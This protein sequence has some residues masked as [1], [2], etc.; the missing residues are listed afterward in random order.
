M[1]SL[2]L[3]IVIAT[4]AFLALQKL[5]TELRRHRR[6]RKL[7]C[8]P[9]NKYP[10]THP[11]GFDIY[12]AR[13]DAVKAGRRNDFDLELFERY[14]S[15]YEERGFLSKIINTTDTANFQAVG[16]T[17]FQ[18]FGREARRAAEPFFGHGILSMNGPQWKQARDLVTPLFK[19]AELMDIEFFK[20]YVDRLL[21]RL[22]RD[23]ST[24]D[25]QPLL[26]KLVSRTGTIGALTYS[27]LTT[28]SVLGQL[29]R[30]HLR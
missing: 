19:R 2:S 8:L 7:G 11:L 25:M 9:V 6:A 27:G 16:T 30:V 23:G 22:P 20:K 3:S 18:D 13:I 12:Q 1:P 26:Q 28:A 24:V 5:L 21:E 14:G 10:H 17:Q 15:T 29:D 4:A